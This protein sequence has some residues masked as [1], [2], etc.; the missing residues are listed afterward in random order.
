M[1]LGA[2]EV[3]ITETKC[4]I[5]VMCLKSSQDHPPHPGS[6]EK[7]SSVKSIS[8]AKRVGDHFSKQVE[9][10]K[11]LNVIRTVFDR[12]TAIILNREV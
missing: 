3:I 1:I 10:R 12:S 8:G 9:C 7:L 11:Y 5:K 6:V 4:T 2:S